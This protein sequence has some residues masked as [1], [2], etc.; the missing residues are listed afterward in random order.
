MPGPSSPHESTRHDTR[1]RLI[2]P[3]SADVSRVFT[4]PRR[5][6]ASYDQTSLALPDGGRGTMKLRAVFSRISSL[7]L[8]SGVRPLVESL[9]VDTDLQV[10][11]PSPLTMR[12]PNRRMPCEPD[13][14]PSDLH[15]RSDLQSTPVASIPHLETHFRVCA[16]AFFSSREPFAA[17]GLCHVGKGGMTS[18]VD[19]AGS[20]ALRR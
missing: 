15:Q 20:C 8:S 18:S 10:G 5:N 19:Q 14:R 11:Y 1:I 16:C 3:P 9:A 4:F 7:Y 2:A 13:E 12:A 6:G 17:R